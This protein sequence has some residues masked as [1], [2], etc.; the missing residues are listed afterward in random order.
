MVLEISPPPCTTS[1]TCGAVG[2]SIGEP[3]EPTALLVIP[4]APSRSDPNAVTRSWRAVRII[5][6]YPE[7]P[8]TCPPRG[9]PIKS[10]ATVYAWPP[11]DS[12]TTF[13]KVRSIPAFVFRRPY[14]PDKV[15]LQDLRRKC[16]GPRRIPGGH[17]SF[18]VRV[19]DDFGSRR[20]E[21]MRVPGIGP[22]SRRFEQFTRR[23]INLA[24]VAG[25]RAC[26]GHRRPGRL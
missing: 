16:A 12:S 7:A 21:E 1:R 10:P 6:T 20:Q 26:T 22:E 4:F 9:F 19:W 13:D 23:W 25:T 18:E 2:G 3:S 15:E 14:G 17:A 11:A 8:G 5:L 24:R